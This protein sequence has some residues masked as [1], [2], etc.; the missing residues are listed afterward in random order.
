VNGTGD[1]ASPA[2]ALEALLFMADEPV[3]LAE[4]SRALEVSIA[5]TRELVEALAESLRGRGLRVQRLGTRVQLVTTPE[6]GP[7]IERFLGARHEQRLSAAALETLAIIAYK[8]PVTRPQVEAIRGVDCGRA[9][10]TLRAREL[11]EELGRAETVGRPLL[12]GTTMR[13]L[14]HF[15]LE[16]PADLPPLPEPAP[17]G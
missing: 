16:H 1:V 8:Q 14:E 4:L 15:G 13:F 7:Y 6:C 5:A 12:Y 2:A 3:E 17:S 9:I 10:A 11:V